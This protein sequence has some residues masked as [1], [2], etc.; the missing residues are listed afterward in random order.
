MSVSDRVGEV[1]RAHARELGQRL[2]VKAAIEDG[3]Q[4]VE[5]G[6]R[7]GR[8]WTE[9]ELRSLELEGYSVIVFAI[10]YDDEPAGAAA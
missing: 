7:S 9:E 5:S 8:V 4:I 3:G 10:V 1:E 2:F 6:D